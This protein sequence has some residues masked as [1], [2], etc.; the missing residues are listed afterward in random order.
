[1]FENV[2]TWMLLLQHSG[3]QI[4][5]KDLVTLEWHPA[6]EQYQEQDHVLSFPLPINM[7]DL[8]VFSVHTFIIASTSR[9]EKDKFLK[10]CHRCINRNK[11]QVWGPRQMTNKFAN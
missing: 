6:L 1:M 10:A 7:Q 5:S 11:R 9:M 3:F 4:S 2:D 8:F